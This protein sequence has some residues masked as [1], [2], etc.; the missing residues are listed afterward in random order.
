MHL[1]NN[2]YITLFLS[3]TKKI[4]TQ[5]ARYILLIII[6]L[7]F[8]ILSSQNC[9]DK[10]VT[11]K[12]LKT[13]DGTTIFG[14]MVNSTDSSITINTNS[15]GILNIPTSQIL[16]NNDVVCSKVKNGELWYENPSSNYYLVAPTAY[17]PGKGNF[18]YR[19]SFL[20]F[21]ILGYGIS[22]HFSIHAGLD[23]LTLFQKRHN[24]ENVPAFMLMP[25]LDYQ[26]AKKLRLGSSLIY[27][28]D[29]NSYNDESIA[30]LLI[31]STYGDEDKNLSFSFGYDLCDKYKEKPVYFGTYT[32]LNSPGEEIEA[33]EKFY[34]SLGGLYRISNRIGFQAEINRYQGYTNNFIFGYG[35]KF[36]TR[37]MSVDFGFVN[38]SF[39]Y[40]EFLIGFPTVSF[41]I[42]V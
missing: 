8:F 24:S 30:I 9:D 1:I 13:K 40:K 18:Y 7:N 3:C 2:L 21:N 42:K 10:K 36:I 5:M 34:C 26:V 6:A 33:I 4:I 19:N 15:L 41:T 32:H 31:S 12:M 23:F 20:L 14:D 22:N 29:N 27:I 28:N 37:K 11:I 39:I 38:S 17:S 35:A 16:S 25:K